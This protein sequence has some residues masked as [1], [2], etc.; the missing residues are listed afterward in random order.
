MYHYQALT[1]RIPIYKNFTFITMGPFRSRCILTCISIR[2]CLKKCITNSAR[3]PELTGHLLLFSWQEKQSP[4]KFSVMQEKSTPYFLF[5]PLRLRLPDFEA[6]PDC[7]FT[8]GLACTSSDGFDIST[9]T[10]KPL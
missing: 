3:N 9:D 7:G 5:P 2:E 4:A 10:G 1:P 8:A 6:D